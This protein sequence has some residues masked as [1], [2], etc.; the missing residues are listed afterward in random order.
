MTGFGTGD[1]PT[2]SPDTP[3]PTQANPRRK[4]G[5]PKGRKSTTP[6]EDRPHRLG[7]PPGTGKLQKATLSDA[8]TQS[9]GTQ[10]EKRRVGR[11]RKAQQRSPFSIPFGSLVSR[12][13]ARL[14]FTTNS[15]FFLITR[16]CP[17]LRVLHGLP[18]VFDSLERR[19]QSDKTHN[20]PPISPTVALHLCPYFHPIPPKAGPPITQPSISSQRRTH[21]A[22]WTAQMMTKMMM[23]SE[24]D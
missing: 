21:S 16:S 9:D 15:F 10:V 6:R 19:L 5:R 14:L 20:H 24:M 3:T 13:I 18:S 22:L 7:R 12:P 8:D 23:L 4:P 2:C 1:E 17:A 11:P